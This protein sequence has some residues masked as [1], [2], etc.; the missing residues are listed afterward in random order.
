M[1]MTEQ[2]HTVPYAQRPL[3]AVRRELTGM[4]AGGIVRLQRW[5][6]GLRSVN[7]NKG[8]RPY[9]ERNYVCMYVRFSLF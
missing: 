5:R 3:P 6:D 9:R 8:T 2:V 4:L 1:A 7:R